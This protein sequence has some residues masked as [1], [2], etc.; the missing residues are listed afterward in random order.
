MKATR[1]IL[2][3]FLA[4]WTYAAGAQDFDDLEFEIEDDSDNGFHFTMD[5]VTKNVWR[6]GFVSS[7]AFEPELSYSIGGLRVGTWA[8]SPFNM[9]TDPY[10]ELDFFI[11][12]NFGGGFGMQVYDYCWT[13]EDENGNPVFN[14]FGPYK[15]NHFLEVGLIYDW[16]EV[17]DNLPMSF[18]INT[19][20][21]GA[22]RKA[23]D[24]QGYTTYMELALEPSLKNLDMYLAV[25][26][27]IEDE[28]SLMFSRKGG[29]NV[30]N[31]DF[32][33]SH[34][35]NIKDVATLSVNGHL[36]CNPT[37]VVDKGEAY[38]LGGVSISF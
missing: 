29:F 24:K 9:N 16:S 35:F 26:A 25:G 18:N 13:L 22:N 17:C 10:N 21:A 19:I 12:Y 32:G 36:I 23:N 7:A 27:A 20:V 1:L 38:V 34:D 11:E 4:M 8:A 30:V 2:A 33:L 28:E 37:G 31:L 5:F 3:A 15:D 6:G 14:Y